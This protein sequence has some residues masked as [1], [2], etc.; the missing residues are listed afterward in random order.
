MGRSGDISEEKSAIQHHHALGNSRAAIA[1]LIG[2]S[3]S[4][5]GDTGA[6]WVLSKG[7]CSMRK[8]KKTTAAD[9]RKLQNIVKKYW[10]VSSTRPTKEWDATMDEP[11]SATTA[12]RCLRQVGYRNRRWSAIKRLLSGKQKINGCSGLPNSRIGLKSNGNLYSSATSQKILRQEVP[13]QCGVRR[14]SGSSEVRQ[15]SS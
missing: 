15:D 2:C 3:K 11:V 13:P 8:A 7:P 10:F 9:V 5:H 14:K 4:I 12:F 6:Q 1:Q